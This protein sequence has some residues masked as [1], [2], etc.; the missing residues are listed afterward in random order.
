VVVKYGGAAMQSSGLRNC[1]VRDIVT[2]RDAGADVVVVHGGGPEL[3]SLQELLGIDTKFVDGL[4]Y[5]DART[6]DAALMALCGK[7]NKDLV[8]MI[9]NEG[10]KAAGLCG[11]DGSI[12]RCRKQSHP[13][14]GFVGEITR[15]RKDLLLILMIG[16][17]IPVVST[18]GLGEDGLAYNINADTA[19]GRIAASLRADYFIT[20]SDIPGVLLDMNDPSSLIVEMDADE[21]EELIKT[22]AITG[23]MIPKVR[24]IC[25]A[26][27]RGACSASIIDGRVPHALL[28]AL[29]GRV[30]AESAKTEDLAENTAAEWT[31]Y[32]SAAT[33]SAETVWD[34]YGAA[35]EGI[36]TELAAA[37]NAATDWASPGSLAAEWAAPGFA[38]EQIEEA[39]SLA[40]K[41]EAE[42]T[43]AYIS[44]ERF[45]GTTIIGQKRERSISL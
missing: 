40:A 28:F 29:A 12:L 32:G 37:D 13:D 23:G 22:G 1:V 2:I 38:F 39:D 24:G 9:E 34:T 14:L 26:V 10:Q 27:K 11:I 35:A 42:K 7:V 15:V 18:V 31:A 3:T 45:I 30:S 20:L 17:I 8:R 16:D 25:D 5:T 44:R 43:K 19:A 6:I 33:E 36:E 41:K 4:R 21:T